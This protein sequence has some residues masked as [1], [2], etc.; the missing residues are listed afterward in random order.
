MKISVILVVYNKRCNEIDSLRQIGKQS[1]FVHKVIVIDNSLPDFHADNR[2]Y[3]DEFSYVIYK[4][5]TENVGLSKAY[6]HALSLLDADDGYV[7]FLDDDTVIGDDFFEKTAGVLE[8]DE[9]DVLFAR[10]E[11]EKGLL[12]PCLR[13][14]LR[15]K[16][17]GA[18]DRLTKHLPK[19]ISAINSGTVVK[20]GVQKGLMFDENLFLDY[21]DHLN[22]IRL[23]QAGH[24]IEISN[25]I[26]RQ[27]FSDNMVDD[28]SQTER[29][30]CFIRDA[31]TFG[32]I[33]KRIGLSTEA[34][35]L[36]RAVKLSIKNRS[37]AYL[38]VYCGSVFHDKTKAV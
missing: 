32:G 12:S 11:D 23:I 16:R 34:Y 24:Q 14:G 5:M 4:A 22:V 17:F 33:I 6:N 26:I 8:S 7:L 37:F 29:Y 3:L 38:K 27:Q 1:N 19:N 21:V 36:F 20:I 15:C 13:S 28:P 18:S 9:P 2:S 10:V 30:R 35:L 25:V 31:R